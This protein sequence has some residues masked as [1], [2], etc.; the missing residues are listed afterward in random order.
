MICVTHLPQIAAMADAHFMIEKSAKEGRSVTEIFELQEQQ[1]LEEIARLL[2][3]SEVTEAVISNAKELKDL[4][5]KT[6]QNLN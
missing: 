1:I 3:G 4:A 2:S 5:T 6:K